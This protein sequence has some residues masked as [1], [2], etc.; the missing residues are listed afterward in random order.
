MSP[1]QAKGK[2]LD[3]R[4]DLFSFGAVLYEM[5]TG[6][7]PFR[8]D[9]T[10]V[11]FEAI[12][13]RTPTPALRVNPDCPPRLDEIIN[14]ALEKDRELRYQHASEIRSDLKRLQRDS[15]SGRGVAAS[16]SPP[17]GEIPPPSRPASNGGGAASSSA[18]SV[19]TSSASA[20]SSSVTAVAREHRAGTIV[21]ALVALALLGAAGFGV[22]SFFNK[23]GPAP[24]QNFTITQ[25]TKTGKAG[26]AAISPDGKY[27]LNVQD[28]NGMQSLW[29]RNV[30][31]GS[32][33]QVIPPAA[34]IYRDLA[35]SPD[36]NYVYYRKAANSQ[37]TQF[38]IYRA[39][40]LGGTPS[41]IVRDVDSDVTFSPDG[42]RIAYIR[43][44]D[45]EPG[46]YRLLEANIDGTDETILRITQSTRGADP[47]HISWSPDGKQIAYSFGSGKEALGYVESF[48]T[49]TKQVSTLAVLKDDRAYGIK[50]L[51]GGHWLLAVYSA[52]GPNFDRNQIGLLSAK[53]EL[54]PITRDTN[55][56]VTLTI[57]ADGTSASTVQLKTTRTLALMDGTSAGKSAS[58]PRSLSQIADPRDV[59]WTPDGK[60]LVSDG[61]TLTRMDPDGRDAVVLLSEP[62]ASISSISA[63]GDRYL[64]FSWGGHA[65][66]RTSAIWRTNADGSAP[67]KVT[68]GPFDTDPLCSADGKSVYYIDRPG[69]SRIMR[70]PIDGGKP[71]QVPGSSIPH[72]FGIE[73]LVSVAPDG[74]TLSFAVDINS[75]AVATAHTQLAIISL[76]GSSTPP[77]LVD[78]DPRIVSS[79]IASV[80]GR[81]AISYAIAENGVSNLWLQP[82]D[83][84]PG[85]QLTHFPSELITNFAWSADGKSVAVL[86][87]QDVADVV[88]LKEGNQ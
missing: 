1:E 12:L 19:P 49:A 64:V 72:Q 6:A 4:T 3:A 78:L 76:D 38:D 58:E 29:L 44:N 33:T 37:G 56:Y 59:R 9:T 27:I 30:P 87:E 47:T 82:L 75:S 65:G 86:R 35:F 81:N 22:Y 32:D 40:V 39:P 42:R 17:S 84:S 20:S 21:A 70:V 11:I 23:S 54:R 15:G 41:A 16:G 25:V 71:E 66:V 34:A 61:P 7:V 2:D 13:N 10:A 46:K 8:G 53:G 73:S 43:A 67:T 31:T 28:D 62:A 57:S 69:I 55:R 83:A 5:A 74:N 50:W 88:L 48:D 68:D 18:P 80:P 63:C 52:F 36:G 26:L 51:P 60:L 14:K 77:K 45:P 85:S 24:F 79:G